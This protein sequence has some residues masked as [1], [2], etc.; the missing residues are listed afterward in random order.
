MVQEHNRPAAVVWSEGGSGYDFIS[1][2]VSDALTHVV[3]TLW[4]SSGEHILDV[5]TG[6]G[7]TARSIASFKSRVTAVD[8]A[9]DLLSAARA[10]SSHIEPTINFKLADAE[11]LPFEDGEFDAVVSTFGVMFAGNHTKAANELS[12]VCRSGGRIVLATW[13]PGEDSFIARMFGI[14]AKHGNMPPP[15]NSP[16]S[17]GVPE[18]VSNLMSGECELNF[19]PQTT[20]LFAP[21][22]AAVWEKFLTGFGPVKLLASRLSPDEVAAFKQDFIGLH[23]EYRVGDQLRIDR[24]YL[25]TTAIRY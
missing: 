6:T 21:S 24:K 5:A 4:P 10:L 14:V 15:E 17:W 13:P 12:R 19:N 25:L 18:Y 22:G 8:I 20:T 11:K 1:F 16:L 7:W 9:D 23:E 2:A 3:Q